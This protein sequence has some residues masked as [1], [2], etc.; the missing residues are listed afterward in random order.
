MYFL[1][2]EQSPGTDKPPG[3]DHDQGYSDQDE[4][5]PIVTA[6]RP[7]K[8]FELQ[9]CIRPIRTRRREHGYIELLNDEPES[10]HGDARAHPG[11]KCSLV[12]SMV[13][14]AADR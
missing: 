6:K 14:E 7:Q 1:V 2:I 9:S 11:E 8:P 10:Y 12:G 3:S 4:S 13:A 5:C